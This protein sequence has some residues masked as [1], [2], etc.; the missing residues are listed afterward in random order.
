MKKNE[1]LTE[2]EP[3]RKNRFIITFPKEYDID[4]WIVNTSTM[5]KYTNDK[6]ENMEITFKDPIGYST[7]ER[8]YK[9]VVTKDKSTILT[10]FT[11]DMLD[12]TGV[13]VE[14][15]LIGIQEIISIDFGDLD[16]SNTDMLNPKIIIKP[17]Y[18]ILNFKD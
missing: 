18:C 13:L 5:P 7:S 8:L 16:Y 4:S 10:Q 12:P 11:I 6:W 9:L 15:W 1:S 14:K 3:K 2:C 17:S